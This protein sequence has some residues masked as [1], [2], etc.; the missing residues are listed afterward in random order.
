MKWIIIPIIVVGLAYAGVTCY[1]NFVDKGSSSGVPDPAKA[2]FTLRIEN[3]GGM[4]L[5]NKLN[6]EG[7]TPGQR[8]YTATGYWEFVGKKFLY[9]NET[10]ILEEKI[11]GLIKVG[12]R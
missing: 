6:Q 1:A 2:R 10:L 4:I 8:V 7:D 12:R 11:F 5:T 9:R 3:T